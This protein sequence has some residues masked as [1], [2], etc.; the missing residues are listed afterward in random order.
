MKKVL[1]SVLFGILGYG[2]FA[3]QLPTV[4]VAPFDVSGGITSEESKVIT[5]LFMVELVSTGAVNVVDR[6]NFDK[7]IGEMKFQT[8]DWSNSQKT[9]A[10][11]NALNASC[12][13]RGQLM[14]MGNA[15]YMTSTLLDV[16]TA[17]I[18]YSAR[19]Q[20]KDLGEIYG[21]L[22]AYCAQFVNK[23]PMPNIFI[24]KWQ[25][26]DFYSKGLTCIF[27]FKS[28]GTIIVERYDIKY[29]NNAVIRCTGEGK[30]SYSRNNLSISLSIIIDF[31][32][33]S[34]IDT[35]S[36]HDIIRRIGNQFSYSGEWGYKDNEFFINSGSL[37]CFVSFGNEESA[38][39]T[40]AKIN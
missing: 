27:D 29:Y 1:V 40:F 12:I 28:D 7:I 13:I 20:V 36:Q 26:S 17:Q 32:K 21:K 33:A 25:G 22:S 24:G 39:L 37:K 2:I 38:Y 16:N 15:I 8:S 3:Q 10:L 18:L 31:S 34:G 14:K 6:A 23:V 4:A 30:Y 35:S 5:E 9:A 11:G 19:E